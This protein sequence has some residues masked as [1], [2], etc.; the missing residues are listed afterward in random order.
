MLSLMLHW[1]RKSYR[2]DPLQVENLMT[3]VNAMK[4]FLKIIKLFVSKGTVSA[5]VQNLPELV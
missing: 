4:T 2:E 5:V 1:S 3:K